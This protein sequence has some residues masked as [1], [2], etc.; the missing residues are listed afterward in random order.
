MTGPWA[1]IRETG[2]LGPLGAA[3]IYETVD[4]VRRF[5]RYPPPQ[6]TKYW[7]AVAKQEV[8]HDFIA[9]DGAEGRLARLVASAIDEDSF[10]R[11]VE[12]AS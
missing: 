2:T 1:E 3:L 12:A 4:V 5:D 7:D 6:G 10:E 11:V 9:A 8:A